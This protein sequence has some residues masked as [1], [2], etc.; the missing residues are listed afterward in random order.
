MFKSHLNENQAFA[1]KILWPDHSEC[2]RDFSPIDVK[3][4]ALCENRAS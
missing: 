1:I 4:E 3:L 2:H